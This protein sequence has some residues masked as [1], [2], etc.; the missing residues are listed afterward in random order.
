MENNRLILGLVQA[1]SE[2][3]RR[4]SPRLMA[5]YTS[6]YSEKKMG[7]QPNTCIMKKAVF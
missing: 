6:N 4:D 7:E 1:F 5:I 3:K 2:S